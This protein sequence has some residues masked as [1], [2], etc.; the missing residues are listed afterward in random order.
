[1]V[2]V[3]TKSRQARRRGCITTVSVLVELELIRENCVALTR[4]L[5][6]YG[7]ARLLRR[8]VAVKT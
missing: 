3:D 2:S 8:V 5:V 6:D 4:K 7:G 1:M